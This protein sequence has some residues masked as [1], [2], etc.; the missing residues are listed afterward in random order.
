MS[1]KVSRRPGSLGRRETFADMGQTIA[2]HLGVG[3]L[4][5]GVDCFATPR[6]A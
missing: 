3:P 4:P 5:A 6:A 2:R 1:A